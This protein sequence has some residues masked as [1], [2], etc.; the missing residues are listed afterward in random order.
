MQPV[1]GLACGLAR[2][3]ARREPVA[4]EV[5]V[6]VRLVDA[7]VASRKLV[8]A[9]GIAPP[10]RPRLLAEEGTAH[11]ARA[12]AAP[13]EKVPAFAAVHV[14][15]AT[16]LLDAVVA[17][18]AGLGVEADV[19]G[20]ERDARELAFRALVSRRVLAIERPVRIAAATERAERLGAA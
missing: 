3:A 8:L 17:A 5:D 1:L 18:R 2:V 16:V 10:R 4:A 7:R 14:Q 11:R 19:L 13:A 9:P 12:P 20:R 15:A 6:R